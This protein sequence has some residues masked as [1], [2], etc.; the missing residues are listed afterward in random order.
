MCRYEGADPA[1]FGIMDMHGMWFI[2]G[3]VVRDFLA[4]NKVEILPWDWGWGFLTAGLGDP[5]P[6]ENQIAFYDEIAALTLAG[7]D[8]FPMVRQTYLD[9]KRWQ[10]PAEWAFTAA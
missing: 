4:L 2:W 10:I 1:K 7:D 3:N 8:R 6:K 5:L 9:E